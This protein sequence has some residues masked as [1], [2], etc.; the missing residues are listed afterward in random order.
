MISL[1]VSF[2][3]R[4]QKRPI[5]RPNP[6]LVRTYSAYF[7]LMAELRHSIMAIHCIDL[8]SSQVHKVLPGALA[9]GSAGEFPGAQCVP[10]S[11][12]SMCRDATV[13]FI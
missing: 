3:G 6:E 8:G 1:D 4:G 10:G 9:L 12:G 11:A 7:E 13:G 5:R 2:L